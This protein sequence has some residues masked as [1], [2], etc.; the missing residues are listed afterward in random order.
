M[1]DFNLA[2]ARWFKWPNHSSFVYVAELALANQLDDL[3]SRYSLG[4]H[5]GKLDATIGEID[6]VS[7]AHSARKLIAYNTS[8][9]G[10]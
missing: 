6:M 8:L 7:I 2:R 5:G 1:Y 4:V 3:K 9:K 10:V